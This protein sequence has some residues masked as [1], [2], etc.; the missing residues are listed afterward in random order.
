MDLDVRSARFCG[1]GL[2][3]GSARFRRGDDVGDAGSVIDSGHWAH[4]M[5]YNVSETVSVIDVSQ[6]RDRNIIKIAFVTIYIFFFFINGEKHRS[7]PA[8]E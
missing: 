8:G 7:P 6:R 4:W 1:G 5:R 3:N 2:G